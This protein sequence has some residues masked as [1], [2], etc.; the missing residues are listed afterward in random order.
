LSAIEG[1]DPRP[2]KCST[3]ADRY[4]HSKTR[5]PACWGSFP[6]FGAVPS[7]ETSRRPGGA[8]TI[9]QRTVWKRA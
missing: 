6:T 5:V 7:S 1:D 3:L 9:D 8:M 4:F 2:S